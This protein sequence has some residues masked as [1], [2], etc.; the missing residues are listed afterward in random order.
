MT[1]MAVRTT[2]ISSAFSFVINGVFFKMPPLYVKKIYALSKNFCK[3]SENP[4]KKIN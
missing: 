3:N 1:P 2:I 4:A